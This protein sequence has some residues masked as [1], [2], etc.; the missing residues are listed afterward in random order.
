MQFFFF[1]WLFTAMNV[2]KPRGDGCHGAVRGDKRAFAWLAPAAFWYCADV[3]KP[4][5]ERG[6]SA[7]ATNPDVNL[8]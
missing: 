8:A 5:T 6:S 3:M 4:A 2:S 1:I 7:R